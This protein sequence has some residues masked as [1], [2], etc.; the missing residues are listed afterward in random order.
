MELNRF[1]LSIIIAVFLAQPVMAEPLTK[2]ELAFAFKDT[3][4]IPYDAGVEPLSGQEN[5]ETKGAI[6]S[7]VAAGIAW[8]WRGVQVLR[9]TGA[10]TTARTKSLREQA[11][12]LIPRNANRHRV[13][14]RSPSQ[15][16]DIDLA[17]RAHAGIPTP[18]TR[19]SPRNLRAPN[20]PA[21]NIR[22]SPVRPAT[23]QD[24]RNVRRYLERL[25]R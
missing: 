25:R 4:E 1:L 9:R 14:L 23:Q 2:K 8:V 3:P 5:R 17:G 21:Y 19:V 20:Q 11:A 7:Y 22:K 16:M 10:G 18:H 24:I 6:W 15:Q 13:R 12:D